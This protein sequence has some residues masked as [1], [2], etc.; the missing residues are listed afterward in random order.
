MGA[1]LLMNVHLL[2]LELV[3]LQLYL[4]RNGRGQMM[5]SDIGVARAIVLV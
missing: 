4:L 5:G 3:Q 1:T 2:A